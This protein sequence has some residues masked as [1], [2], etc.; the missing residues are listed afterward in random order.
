MYWYFV[1]EY[2]CTM[3]VPGVCGFP[4]GLG[5]PGTGVTDGCESLCGWF[6]WER[7]VLLIIELSLQPSQEIFQISILIEIL[8]QSWGDGL[9]RKVPAMQARW[10]KF[11]AWNPPRGENQLQEAALGPPYVQGDMRVPPVP[12]YTHSYNNMKS[13]SSI[14]SRDWLSILSLFICYLTSVD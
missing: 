9:A 6:R 10:S 13:S 2:M 12:S 14:L 4:G 3:C 5:L 7:S 8:F 11:H 1:F